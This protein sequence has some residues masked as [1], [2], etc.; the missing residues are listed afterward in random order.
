MLLGCG[1]LFALLAASFPRMALLF[2]WVFTPLVD[3]AFATFVGPLLG[4]AFLP[5]TTIMYVLAFPVIGWGWF[6]VLLGLIL[7]IGIYAGGAYRNRS[8][9]QGYETGPY[10]GQP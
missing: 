4:L 1:C 3:H 9:I 2:I 8:Q 6:W 10:Y 5:F 7:D